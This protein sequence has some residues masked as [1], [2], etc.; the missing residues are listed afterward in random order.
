MAGIHVGV[1]AVMVPLQE[2]DDLQD[3]PDASVP[4]P[5]P[6]WRRPWLRIAEAPV[7]GTVVIAV[8]LLNT[9]TLALYY[10]RGSHDYL[11]VLEALNYTWTAVFV[12]ELVVKVWPGMGFRALGRTL[13]RLRWPSFPEPLTAICAGGTDGSVWCTRLFCEPVEPVR[14]SGCCGFPD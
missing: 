2:P 8:I 1:L 7:F 9:L 10:P 6:A 4:A 11:M 12:V 5:L 13:Q 3:L 14:F